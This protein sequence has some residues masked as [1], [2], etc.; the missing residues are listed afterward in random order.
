MDLQAILSDGMDFI[1]VAQDR[2][3]WTFA[4]PKPRETSCLAKQLQASLCDSLNGVSVIH[5]SIYS[6]SQ[7]NSVGLVTSDTGE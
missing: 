5:L 6:G 2:D 3:Q 4:F 7:G 1:H